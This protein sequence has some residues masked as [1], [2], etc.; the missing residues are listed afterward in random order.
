MV[1]ISPK[2]LQLEVHGELPFVAGLLR[3]R[4]LAELRVRGEGEDTLLLMRHPEILTVGRRRGA[5]DNILD[6]EIPVVE[7]DRGGDVTW[8]GP[9]QIVGYPVLRLG[10]DERDVHAVLRRL[11]GGLMAVLAELGLASRRCP[12]HTGV[13][14]EPT[15]GGPLRK[16]C[17]IGIGVR[18]WVARHGFSLNVD[19]DL[20]RQTLIKPCGLD[21]E[22][23]GS[24]ASLG[25]GPSQ[26]AGLDSLLHRHLAAAFGRQAWGAGG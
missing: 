20:T 14:V 23:M 12:P 15:P 16:V 11:E 4:E 24:L 7:V 22:V 25:V 3:M 26:R 21:S 8:H 1:E 18:A 9:G 5:R 2:R 6:F 13:W 19:N 17:S 10:A